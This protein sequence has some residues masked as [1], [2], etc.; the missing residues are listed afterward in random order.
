ME[1]S[2][3]RR[4]QKLGLVSSGRIR[5]VNQN[6]QAALGDLADAVCSLF[7]SGNARD[8]RFNDVDVLASCS[9]LIQG[10]GRSLASDQSKNGVLGISRLA[11]G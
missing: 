7:E 5:V 10:T 11:Y 9:Q 3:G 4:R 1:Y 2:Q 8:V 6:V